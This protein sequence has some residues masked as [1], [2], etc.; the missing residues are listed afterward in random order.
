MAN[1]KVF[2]TDEDQDQDRDQSRLAPGR[3]VPP[4]INRPVWDVLMAN[5]AKAREKWVGARR[6]VILS[7]LTVSPAWQGMGVGGALMQWGVR[8]ADE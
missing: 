6:I 3:W 1:W 8:R 5:M 2:E 4:E 7:S